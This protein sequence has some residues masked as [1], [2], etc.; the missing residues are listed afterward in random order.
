MVWAQSTEFFDTRGL[1]KV[2]GTVD[3]HP[4][5]SQPF[6]FKPTESPVHTP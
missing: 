6:A 3:G 1:V 4:F 2:A 5:R